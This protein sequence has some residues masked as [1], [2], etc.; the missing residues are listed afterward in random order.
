MS[1]NASSELP[2]PQF[3]LDEGLVP[4]VAEALTLVGYSITDLRTA[5]DPGR[6]DRRIL[7]PE[8]IEWCQTRG[9]VWIHAD[10]RARKEHR[11]LLQTSGIRTL[12]IYRPHGMMTAREQLRILAFVLPKLIDS[13][14]RHPRRR[15][16]RASAPNPLS[17]PSFRSITL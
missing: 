12:W 5:M 8:V 4:R 1:G 16:Y 15:H 2:N 13:Y 7:D 10:D 9:S 11:R 14:E 17:T 6:T 3:L